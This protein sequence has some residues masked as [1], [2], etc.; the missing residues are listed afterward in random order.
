M[1]KRLK[2]RRQFVSRMPKAPVRFLPPSLN[3]KYSHHGRSANDVAGR[4]FDLEDLS[5]SNRRVGDGVASVSKC[6][7]S[8]YCHRCGFKFPETAKF[9]CECG[10][11]RLVLWKPS[12]WSIVDER[13]ANDQLSGRDAQVLFFFF[14]NNETK[15]K[16]RNGRL[17]IAETR[18]ESI[19]IGTY[20][21]IVTSRCL[22]HEWHIELGIGTMELKK[23]E[24]ILNIRRANN[25]T[26]GKRRFFYFCSSELELCVL[27]LCTL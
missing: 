22:R 6:K 13:D 24:V 4:G 14:L 19:R 8:K 1:H 27:Y 21:A 11:R 3:R 17:K 18:R 2:F 16:F 25:T 10:I 7:M 9:C 12:T 20:E 23:R 15:K 26:L 5:R